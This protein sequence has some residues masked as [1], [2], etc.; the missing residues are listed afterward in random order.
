MP[1]KIKYGATFLVNALI[2]CITLLSVEKITNK[3][4]IT[5]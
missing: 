2:L 5:I 3:K 1:A 4:L